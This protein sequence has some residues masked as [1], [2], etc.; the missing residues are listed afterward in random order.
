VNPVSL[1]DIGRLSIRT[2]MALARRAGLYLGHELM[3]SRHEER[4]VVGVTMPWAPPSDE[5]RAYLFREVQ[6]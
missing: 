2:T 5:L 1:S 4:G 3:V 6:A